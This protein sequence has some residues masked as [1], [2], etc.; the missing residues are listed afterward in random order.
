IEIIPFI[1]RNIT[2]SIVN[3]EKTKISVIFPYFMKGLSKSEW[4]WF[5]IM[6]I[7]IDIVEN[8]AGMFSLNILWSRSTANWDN[9]DE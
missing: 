7:I 8:C 9:C 2:D 6:R 4:S 1:Y 3:H 5:A